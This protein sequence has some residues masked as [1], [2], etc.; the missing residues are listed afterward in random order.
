MKEAEEEDN[1]GKDREFH[2]CRSGYSPRRPQAACDDEIIRPAILLLAA[3]A[4][5]FLSGAPGGSNSPDEALPPDRDEHHKGA[6]LKLHEKRV[7]TLPARPYEVTRSGWSKALSADIPVDS[8]RNKTKEE[9]NVE[10]GRGR[11]GVI[12]ALS[13]MLVFNFSAALKATAGSSA[14]VN[15]TAFP[16][17]NEVLAPAASS[18]E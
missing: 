15:D 9:E 11:E 18:C 8:C 14:P 5:K 4:A 12:P 17:L 13:P 10:E 7:A 3:M 16:G 6:E 2:A 1:V